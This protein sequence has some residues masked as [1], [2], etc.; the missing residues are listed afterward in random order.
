MHPGHRVLV[1]GHRGASADLPENTL[2][3]ILRARAD[4]AD[5]VEI[6]VRISRDGV[7]V[8]LHDESLERTTGD[9]RRLVDVNATGLL[10]L[11]AGDGTPP[12]R[13]DEVVGVAPLLIDLKDP[14]P[15]A[16]AEVVPEGADVLVQSRDVAAMR[17]LKHLRPDLDV[18]VLARP[19]AHDLGELATWSTGV[20]VHHLRLTADYVALLHAHGLRCMTWT[21]NHPFMVD[22]VL[23]LG[24]DGI[25]TDRSGDVVRAVSSARDARTAPRRHGRVRRARTAASPSPSAGS[26]YPTGGTGPRRTSRRAG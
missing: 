22:R 24:V 8:L 2:P 23:Q 9:P 13:L 25:I 1:A 15:D 14:V 7:L 18:A 6:D 17:R 11:D 20:H 19:H 21:V 12:P 4:G 16:V 10:H 3:A 5:L 26:P